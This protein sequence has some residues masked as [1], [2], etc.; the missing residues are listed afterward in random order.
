M[1]KKKLNKVY[2]ILVTIGD[3]NERMRESFIHYHLRESGSHEWRFSGNLGFGGKYRLD[4]NSVD[5]YS[6]DETPER[7]EIIKRI[8]EELSKI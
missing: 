1:N 6:E 8:N 4:E 2:D 5:C 3:A 7:F